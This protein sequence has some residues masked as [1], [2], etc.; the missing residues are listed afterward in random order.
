MV[1]SR[2]IH[3]SA[4]KIPQWNCNFTP[5]HSFFN[6]HTHLCWEV[7]HRLKGV[8]HKLLEKK[9][10]SEVNMSTEMNGLLRWMTLRFWA[11]LF[12]LLSSLASLR[13]FFAKPLRQGSF[14][15]WEV[16]AGLKYLY[17]NLISMDYLAQL[18]ICVCVYKACTILSVGPS[19]C[20]F[21]IDHQI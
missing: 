17:N 3:G 4:N 16:F 8:E 9:H 11:S 20:E 1:Y 14:W 6:N 19:V 12:F 15:C 21:V 5:S 18:Y 13:S 7:V 2:K 10:W